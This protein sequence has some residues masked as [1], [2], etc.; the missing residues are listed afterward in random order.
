[1]CNQIDYKLQSQLDRVMPRE[2]FPCPSEDTVSCVY[3]LS[4]RKVPLNC[5]ECYGCDHQ[6]TSLE[7]HAKTIDLKAPVFRGGTQQWVFIADNGPMAE[8][9]RDGKAIVKVKP[10]L[11]LWSL[12]I[13]FSGHFWLQT[14]QLQ[15]LILEICKNC[16]GTVAQ[17][18]MN[19]RLKFV[20][21]TWI[22][23]TRPAWSQ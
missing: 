13:Y 6:L 4:P 8:R 15:V 5:T 7:S 3:P 9:S 11:Q 14:V 1:M 20:K 17:S 21:S 18:A 22:L 16:V 19:W 12:G 2:A 23:R 10:C